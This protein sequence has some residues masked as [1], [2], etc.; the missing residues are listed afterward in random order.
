MDNEN[1]EQIDNSQNQVSDHQIQTMFDNF[2]LSKTNKNKQFL[3]KFGKEFQ[4][5]LKNQEWI[6]DKND[7]LIAWVSA[8]KGI[9]NPKEQELAK[10]ILIKVPISAKLLAGITENKN[11]L[12]KRYISILSKKN[13]IWIVWDKILKEPWYPNELSWKLKSLYQ[14]KGR[15]WKSIKEPT[16][17]D[18]QNELTA[19]TRLDWKTNKPPTE[20]EKEKMDIENNKKR[21]ALTEQSRQDLL[22][23]ENYKQKLQVPDSKEAQ[24]K[25]VGNFWYNNIDEAKQSHQYQTLVQSWMSFGQFL[26]FLQTKMVAKTDPEVNRKDFAEF[27]DNFQSLNLPK[28]TP[29]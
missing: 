29:K 27:E 21:I 19:L 4:N 2:S 26:S 17:F 13:A 3:L 8:M 22:K 18:P 9:T 5:H 1:L 24:D 23:N 7:E 15:I 20:E 25:L 28:P 14:K 12:L 16:G 6:T 11:S 10:L